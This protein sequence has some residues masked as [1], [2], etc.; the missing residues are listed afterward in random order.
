MS[1]DDAMQTNA[2]MLKPILGAMQTMGRLALEGVMTPPNAADMAGYMA[3]FTPFGLFGFWFACLEAGHAIP[4]S[5]I[6]S[7]HPHKTQLRAK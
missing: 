5:L 2:D 7:F 6:E 3:M 1:K 4:S